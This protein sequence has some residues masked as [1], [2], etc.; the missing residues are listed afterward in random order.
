[1]R[2]GKNQHYFS[3]SL[4]K[5]NLKLQQKAASIEN[6][7]REND[8]EEKN[9]GKTDSSTEE[10]SKKESSHIHV[11]KMLKCL[12][13]HIDSTIYGH[14]IKLEEGWIKT[15]ETLGSFLKSKRV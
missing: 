1:M 6:Q 11:D 15:Q 5:E 10:R 8:E 13:E 3:N 2:K 14:Y 12:E 4:N 9:K 7:M